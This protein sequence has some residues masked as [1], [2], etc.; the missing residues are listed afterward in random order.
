MGFT[1]AGTYDDGYISSDDE[2]RI[3]CDQVY[4]T[5]D[6]DKTIWTKNKQYIDVEVTVN[7]GLFICNTTALYSWAHRKI[8]GQFPILMR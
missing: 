8:A 2:G 7:Q 4:D 3:Y 1:R 6:L 5:A